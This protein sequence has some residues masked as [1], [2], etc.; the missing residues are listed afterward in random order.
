M[1]HLIL[2]CPDQSFTYQQVLPPA[3]QVSLDVQVDGRLPDYIKLD[4]SDGNRDVNY[5]T[6]VWNDWVIAH[7]SDANHRTAGGARLTRRQLD[8]LQSLSEGMTGKQ[9]AGRLRISQRAVSLHVSGLKRNLNAST[10]AECIQKSRP[11]GD[12]QTGRLICV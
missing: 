8:V 10:T 11:A 2:I 3:G 5:S 9:I 7:P 4:G 6:V 12:P 1:T